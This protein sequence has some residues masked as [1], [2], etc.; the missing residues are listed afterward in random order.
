M[1]RQSS[2][3]STSLGW[4][5]ALR[6]TIAA[7][8]AQKATH[9][10]DITTSMDLP[11]VRGSVADGILRHSSGRGIEL[12][13]ARGMEVAGRGNRQKISGLGGRCVID[14]R[15]SEAVNT[16]DTV[17]GVAPN[18]PSAHWGATQ[19][20]VHFSLLFPRR[21]AWTRADLRVGSV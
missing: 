17:T 5:A 1:A 6:G 7:Q 19:L 4:N 20:L 15:T 9:C 13:V 8:E 10:V 14:P 21:S 2:V 18:W 12:E 3:Y 16:W 11:S